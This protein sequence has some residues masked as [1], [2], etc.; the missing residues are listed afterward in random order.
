MTERNKSTQ[1]QV[2]LEF[3]FPEKL[4]QRVLC[5]HKKTF[6]TAGDFIEYLEKAMDE[7]ESGEEED[8]TNTEEPA[9]IANS[10]PTEPVAD[11]NEPTAS[12]P[13]PKSLREETEELYLRSIC[14]KCYKRRRCFVSLPCSHFNLCDRCGPISSQC[15]IPDCREKI[16]CIIQT[17][18]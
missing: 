8:V 11:K 18:F 13:Q 10:P 3:D 15:P 5:V 1:Y 17:Y 6:K 16:D 4:V 14:L 2:A 12:S 9:S 7:Y